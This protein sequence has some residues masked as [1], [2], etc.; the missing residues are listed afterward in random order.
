MAAAPSINISKIDK[1]KCTSI[2]LEWRIK[3]VVFAEPGLIDV[4]YCLSL[5]Y[6]TSLALLIGWLTLIFYENVRKKVYKI[7]NTFGH[8]KTITTRLLLL[9]ILNKV[10]S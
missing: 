6:F 9:H 1:K 3:N 7:P 10:T 4:K 5:K 2:G 8:S